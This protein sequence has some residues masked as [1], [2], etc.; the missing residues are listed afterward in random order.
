MAVGARITSTNLSGKT[1]TVTFTPYTGLTSGT[2]ENLGTKT[3]PFNNINTHPYGD[4]NL[5]F[6]EYDYTYTL[7]VPEPDASVQSF[8]YLNKMVGSDNYGVAFLNFNDFTAEIIDLGV[9]TN[10]WN[11]NNMYVLD[12]SGYMHYFTGENDGDD[13]LV[14]FT[15]AQHEEIGRYSGTTGSTSRNDLEGKWLTFED[16]DN[17]VLTYSNGV[18]VFTYTWDPA[19]YYVDIEYNWDA[20]TADGTMILEK[21]EVEP[22]SGW[23]YNG[24]GTSHIVNPTYGTTTLFKTWTDGTYIRHKITPSSDFIVVLT[25]TQGV[26]NT[27]TNFQI[28]DTSGALLET[29][30]L[31]QDLLGPVTAVTYNDYYEEFHGTNKF[32]I[33]FYDSNS[34]NTRYKI[35]SY[36]GETENLIVAYHDRGPEYPSINTRADRDFWPNDDGNNG[37]I[38]ITLYN[39]VT[40]NNIGTEVTYCDI[41]YMFDNQTSFS[42]YTFADDESKTINSYGQLSDIYRVSCVNGDDVASMLTIMSGSTRIESM[43]VSVSGITNMDWWQLGNR[44]VVQIMTNN[45]NTVTYKYIN[46]SGVVIGELNDYLLVSQWATGLISFGETAYISIRMEGD[47]A[48]YVYSGSTVFTETDYYN[49]SSDTQFYSSPTSNYDG[50]MV[51]YN[52]DGLGFRILTPTGITN[53]FN[54]PEYN[55]FYIRV[56][57]SKFMFVYNETSGGVTKIRLYDFSGTLLNSATTTWTNGWDNTYGVKD[58]FVVINY[59]VDDTVEIYLV[60]EDTITSVTTQ[61]YSSEEATNDWFYAND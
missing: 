23:T 8:A 18:E 20:T 51:L 36:N 30:S 28:Y 11:S 42:T 46:Q 33:V 15:D 43:N 25:E 5:Y 55:Q 45:N 60:S 40:S 2:T 50:A 7:N 22:L 31:N 58:R 27:Y 17:G 44:T 14:I 59:N 1:A 47:I 24:P 52:N 4:Y 38:V 54:F 13:R 35:I 57:E 16:E 29:V 21:W 26:T 12:N 53:E 19:L 9:D 3:I 39:Y 48:Y 6:A 10:V 34:E 61:D 37:G 49:N 32:T 56:G 41:M